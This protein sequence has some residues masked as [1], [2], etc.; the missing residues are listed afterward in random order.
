VTARRVVRELRERK[1][2]IRYERGRILVR[3]RALIT[4]EMAEAIRTHREALIW[5]LRR[6]LPDGEPHEIWVTP[7]VWTE[8][9]WRTGG[10]VETPRLNRAA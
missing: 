9:T 10:F 2:G 5:L 7:E 6:R 8:W 3:P 4:D 1:I